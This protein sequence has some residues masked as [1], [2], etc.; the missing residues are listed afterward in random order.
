MTENNAVPVLLYDGGC[1]VCTR[2]GNWVS[3][4]ARGNAGRQS[5]IA[6]PVGNDPAA[7]RRLNP[8][9]D[10]W[11]AYTVVHV[12][13][14]DGT[15]KTGGEAVAEVLRRLPATRWFSGC[16]TLG[17]LGV[18]PFQMGLNV[19]YRLLDDVRPLLGCDS[20]GHSRSWVRPFERLAAWAQSF[21][22]TQQAKSPLHFAPLAAPNRAPARPKSPAPPHP[23][24]ILPAPPMTAQSPQTP[25]AA[26]PP[27]PGRSINA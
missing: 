16:F 21:F 18:R 20:C 7:L 6:Q 14:P 5:I 25:H 17:V 19:A 10:I 2:I 11:Q 13:M 23:P 1:Q 9:L 22:S 15:M 26:S 8:G 12:I 3:A 24:A 4:S 27:A